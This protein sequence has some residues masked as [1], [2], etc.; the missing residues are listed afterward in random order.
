MSGILAKGSK[1]AKK[2][3]HKNGLFSFGTKF[4]VLDGEQSKTKDGKPH[5]KLYRFFMSPFV[6]VL[7]LVIGLALIVGGCYC[8]INAS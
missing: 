4:F 5:G 2:N 8:A 7:G 6:S 1:S 3:A